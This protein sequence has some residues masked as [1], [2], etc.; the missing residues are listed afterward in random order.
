MQNSRGKCQV[1]I[2]SPPRAILVAPVNSEE[3]HR[4]WREWPLQSGV[5]SSDS[6]KDKV[7][8]KLPRYFSK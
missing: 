6:W 8:E 7:K 5:C 1:V 4:G 3:H 2:M